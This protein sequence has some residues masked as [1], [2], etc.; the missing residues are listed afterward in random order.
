[1]V[2][3]IS[4]SNHSLTFIKGSESNKNLVVLFPMTRSIKL[5]SGRWEKLISTVNESKVGTL[6][7]IDKTEN[8]H[9]TD[10][11]VE[12]KKFITSELVI[13]QRPRDE[14]T[15]DSQ[16]F[17]RL[18]HGLWILQMHDDDDWNGSIVLPL[19]LNEMTILRTQFTVVDGRKSVIAQNFN[20]PDCRSIFSILPAPVWNHFAKMIQ[21]QGGHVAGSIDSSLNLVVSKLEPSILIHNF[22]YIYDNRHWGTRRKANRQL[23]KI[24]QEDG[25]GRFATIEISLVGR[26][27]DGISSLIYF[28]SFLNKEQFESQLATWIKSTK[29]RTLR[30]RVKFIQLT[31][32][33]IWIRLLKVTGMAKNLLD[34]IEHKYIYHSVLL[35][36]WTGRDAE[37]YLEVV[38]LLLQQNS[39]AS[40]YPRF[41][42]WKAQLEHLKDNSRMG[43]LP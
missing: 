15:H 24:T 36:S 25:W 29:P 8:H 6:V 28:S 7:L 18:E 37:D 5:N 9:A 16:T 41:S 32:L 1:M 14:P 42:F 20:E 26:T 10:F 40:L 38:G 13:L 23:R 22:N 12:H 19:D 21:E 27:I 34:T 11:F 33:R 4:A 39:L 31:F 35:K 3:I 43:F 17:I 30:L 2:Q